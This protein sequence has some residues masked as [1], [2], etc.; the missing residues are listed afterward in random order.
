MGLFYAMLRA[1]RDPRLAA[2]GRPWYQS[3]DVWLSAVAGLLL[4]A[5]AYLYFG[6]YRGV[7]APRWSYATEEGPQVARLGTTGPVY[8][9]EMFGD[10][11][12]SGWVRFLAQA[13][14]RGQ[15][16]N[17][18]AELPLLA[19]HVAD[20]K[21]RPRP[22]DYPL[23]VPHLGSGASFIVYPDPNQLPYLGL[24]ESLYLGGRLLD[25]M[26]RGVSWAASVKMPAR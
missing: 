15:V 6:V 18:G 8:A 10:H 3:Q 17:P 23:P 21:L 9:V 11:I 26:G 22:S 1:P 12:N 2:A 20:L 5:N 24:L 4:V 16:Q 19:T 7:M 25:G 14:V 13:A